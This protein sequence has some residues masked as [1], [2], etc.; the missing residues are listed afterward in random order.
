M[1]CLYNANLVLPD[2]IVDR[3]WVQVENGLI[4][5]IGQGAPPDDLHRFDGKGFYLAPGFIDLHV[6]GA[7]GSDFLRANPEQF[8]TAANFHLSG[9]TTSL[10]PT[11]ATASYEEFE[12]FLN[13]WETARGLAKGRL[14]PVHLEGPHLAPSKAGA[15]DSKLMTAPTSKQR[16]WVLSRAQKVSQMTIAPPRLRRPEGS[17]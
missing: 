17:G 16:D 11:A 5:A 4:K 10:C 2:R 1:P 7:M 13:V 12:L 8:L 3:G 14:L 6:H 15:Q 9:G